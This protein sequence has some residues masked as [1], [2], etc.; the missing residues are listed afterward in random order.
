MS[1]PESA[2][3]AISKYASPPRIK[4]NVAERNYTFELGGGVEQL[5]DMVKFTW[6]MVPNGGGA[7]AATG[8]IV[9]CWQKMAGFES[10]INL[11]IRIDWTAC[12]RIPSSS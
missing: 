8:L 12:P 6:R 7:I 1:G 10:T 9:C 5:R 4:P 3:H 2:G 11:S